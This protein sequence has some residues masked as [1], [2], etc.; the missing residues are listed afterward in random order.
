MLCFEV[1]FVLVWVRGI[2][3]STRLLNC[4]CVYN[5][6]YLMAAMPC[7]LVEVH[8]LLRFADFHGRG[9]V[10]LIFHPFPEIVNWIRLC[11]LKN[12]LSDKIVVFHCWYSFVS[13][14]FILTSFLGYAYLRQQK[15]LVLGQAAQ[16]PEESSQL[17][18]DCLCTAQKWL[19]YHFRYCSL[20]NL[21]FHGLSY[22]WVALWHRFVA[23]YPGQNANQGTELSSGHIRGKVVA[24][25]NA[26][27]P[28]F[29]LLGSRKNLWLYRCSCLGN[30]I[31]F[32]ELEF[33][34]ASGLQLMG[35]KLQLKKFL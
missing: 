2:L 14:L 3:N 28:I 12:C 18:A 16:M 1:C 23:P 24:Q 4:V 11:K 35:R 10:C 7:V 32:C 9:K 22:A 5:C 25:R 20:G 21:G 15:L 8:L 30:S 29:Y 33:L 27:P 6:L 17:S 34:E 26:L 13:L 31:L 19:E